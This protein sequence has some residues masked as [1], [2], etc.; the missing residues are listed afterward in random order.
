MAS[1]DTFIFRKGD[2]ADWILDFS[3]AQGDKLRFLDFGYASFAAVPLV[4]LSTPGNPAVQLTFSAR[5]AST[6][7]PSSASRWR[8]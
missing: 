3:A 2:S 1:A 7:S 6:S 8:S 4:D 5:A